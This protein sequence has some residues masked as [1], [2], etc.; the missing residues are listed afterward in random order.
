MRRFIVPLLAGTAVLA[1]FGIARAHDGIPAPTVVSMKASAVPFELF[2][3]NRVVVSAKLNGHDVPAILDTGASATTIDRAY[4]R[5]IGIPEG[6][7]IQGRG[8]GGI[9]EAELVSNVTL[10]IG[11]V[12]FEKMTVA[13]MDLGPVA[14]AI[15]RPLPLV[16]GRELF[17]NAALSFDWDRNLLTI[18]DS[19]HFT[20]PP[21]ATVLPVER[22]GPFN[23]VKLSV[24]G[25]PTIDAVLDL[26]AG[27]A[28]SLPSD[29][30]SK[31]PALASLRFADTQSGGVGGIHSSRAVTLPSVEFAGRRFD[32]VPAVLGGDSNGG[33]AE[34]GSNLGIGMLKQFALTL[35]L[36]HDRIFL[37]ARSGPVPFERDRAGVRIEQQGAK[38]KVTFAS[39]Q[40]PAARAGLK[41][42]DE[43]VAIDGQ[44]IPADF[45]SSPLG[46]LTRA[47]AGTPV[48]LGLADGRIVRFQLED[49]F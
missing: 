15:G 25:L 41:P 5:S 35:D 19:A 29:Y 9:V 6:Q 46:N 33:A 21:N 12:K 34:R 26:G 49:Y 47:A 7:K 38:L 28:I 44:P 30:W 17:N 13:V 18:A 14:K 4:A 2:R 39:A 31:Q 11:G 3:G 40:G 24:A 16:V 42:G 43:I 37:G 23:F 27:G 20:P 45:Y 8:A 48:T 32:K 36:G 22:R 10:E 1:A